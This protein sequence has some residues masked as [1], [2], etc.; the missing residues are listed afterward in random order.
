MTPLA[1]PRAFASVLRDWAV[2][3]NGGSAYGS[4]RRAAEELLVSPSNIAHWLDGRPCNFERP[5]RLL[6]TMISDRPGGEVGAPAAG[7]ALKAPRPPVV[8]DEPPLR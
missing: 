2:T 1:D 3:I 7:V 8:A 4:R 5:L 6:M